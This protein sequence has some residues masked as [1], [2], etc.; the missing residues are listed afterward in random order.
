MAIISLFRMAPLPNAEVLSSVLVNLFFCGFSV[1]QQT[2]KIPLPLLRL[3]KKLS[4]G[5][6]WYIHGVTFLYLNLLS[7]WNLFLGKLW[8]K[9]LTLFFSRWLPIYPNEMYWIIHFSPLIWSAQFP[10]YLSQSKLLTVNPQYIRI[11]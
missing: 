8:G 11:L 3:Q 7:I 10:C 4:Y 1:L 9:D 5:F 2:E 6:F